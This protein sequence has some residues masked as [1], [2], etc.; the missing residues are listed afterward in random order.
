MDGLFEQNYRVA[1][2]STFVPKCNHNA[3]FEI[4]R[5]IVICLN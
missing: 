2:L 5:T 3:E 1:L 4:D